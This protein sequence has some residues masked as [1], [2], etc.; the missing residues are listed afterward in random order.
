M[1]TRSPISS[2]W[3]IIAGWTAWTP[4][5]SMTPCWYRPHQVRH[6]EHRDLVDGLEA[7]EAGPVGR[8][9][10]VVVGGQAHRLATLGAARESRAACRAPAR[11]R[12]GPTSSMV[13]SLDCSLTTVTTLVLPRL[14]DRL[15]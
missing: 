9:A 6:G 14:V 11:W 1:A 7:A 2:Q 4:S 8:V 5:R 13:I 12:R 3:A 10:D 15:S